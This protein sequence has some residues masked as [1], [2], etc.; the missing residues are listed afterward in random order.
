MHEPWEAMSPREEEEKVGE[1]CPWQARPGCQGRQCTGQSGS[2]QSS[3]CAGIVRR[4]TTCSGCTGNMLLTPYRLC[5][6]PEWRLASY[7][8][9]GLQA[10]CVV[11]CV[12]II[13]LICVWFVVQG[14]H[15]VEDAAGS[16]SEGHIQAVDTKGPLAD[17]HRQR[18]AQLQGSDANGAQT[19]ASK[20][21]AFRFHS[22]LK[23]CCR[24][25]FVAVWSS[26]H[27]VNWGAGRCPEW[28][29][30]QPGWVQSSS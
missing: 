30:L 28:Q 22:M 4:P 2:I 29:I 10:T 12:V 1:A 14:G 18:V 3:C 23:G 9:K 8:A 7:R 16:R 20:K 13:L 11:I 15:L 24:W 21:S 5:C 25:P 27:R 26:D 17:L 6:S 19:P